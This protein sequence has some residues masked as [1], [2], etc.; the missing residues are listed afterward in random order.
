[1]GAGATAGTGYLSLVV[2]LQ[3]HQR[4]VLTQGLWQIPKVWIS[5]AIAAGFLG[6]A[7]A[8]LLLA[9]RPTA[10]EAQE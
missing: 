7:A 6:A 3:H 10:T 1:M 8:F 2:A 9:F 4:G 5:G